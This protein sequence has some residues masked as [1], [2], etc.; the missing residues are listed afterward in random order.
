MSTIPLMLVLTAAV[1][2]GAYNLW[3][4]WNGVEALVVTLHSSGLPDDDPVRH[5]GRIAFYLLAAAIF[6]GFGSPL[7]RRTGFANLAI[8]AHVGAALAGFLLV[9]TL[10]ARL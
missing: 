8:A 4:W 6:T 2:L 7:L 3:G 1:A 9:L 5:T 10:G